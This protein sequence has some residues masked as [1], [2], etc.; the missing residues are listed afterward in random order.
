MTPSSDPSGPDPADTGIECGMGIGMRIRQAR[1]SAGLTQSALARQLGVSP[2]T[3]NRWEGGG[4][5]P[6]RRVVARLA[7]I[8]GVTPGVLELGDAA[9]PVPTGEFSAPYA[10]RS[11]TPHTVRAPT[12]P[13]TPYA[14]I[15]RQ[16]TTP[17]IGFQGE[18]GAYSHLA[19]ETVFPARKAHGFASF[20]DVFAAVENGQ[21]G[22]AMIPIENSLGGRV[23]DIHHLLP[24][25]GLYIVGEYF[26]P[27]HHR[28][29]APTGAQLS[30]IREVTSHPQAL[31][32]CRK[33]LREMQV[34]QVTSSDTAGAARAVAADNDPRR[35]AIASSLAARLY[36]L[37]ILRNRIEDRLG[38]VTRFVVMARTRIEPAPGDGPCLTSFVFTLRSVPASLYKSMGGF[39]TNG[40]NMI[41][42]ESYISISDDSVARFYAEIEGHPS[43]KAVDRAFEELNFFTS[44][45]KLIGTYIRNPFRDQD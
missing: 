7:A 14:V 43:D 24:E 3:F 32:Q 6:P 2:S 40:V 27:I 28:L 8:L 22:L 16:V 12:T 20:E 21:V 34:A 29:V 10:V 25:T 44:R 4:R 17:H 41:R 15:D 1:M 33:T 39:A 38:N 23:A 31:A 5:E 18:P 35:A 36:G 37:E 13:H 42:L 45:V 26:L 30:D 19:C 9:A 11:A